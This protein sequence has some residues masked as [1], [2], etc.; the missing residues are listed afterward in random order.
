MPPCTFEIP[1]KGHQKSKVCGKPEFKDG[2]CQAHQPK[3]LVV[4]PTAVALSWIPKPKSDE[5]VDAT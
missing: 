4:A 5:S 1:A 3:P 2:L